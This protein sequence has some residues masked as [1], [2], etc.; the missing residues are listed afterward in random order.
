MP[1]LDSAGAAA[2]PERTLGT[3]NPVTSTGG[4]LFH[5]GEI[6]TS[7]ELQAMRLDGLVQLVIG[8]SYLRSDFREDAAARSQAAARSVPSSLRPR[9]ALGRTCAAWVYGCAPRPSLI[10][11]V[12]DH[13]RRTTALPPFTPAVLHQVALGPF[14]VN[15]VGGVSVTTPLRTALDI[16]VHGEDTGAVEILRAIGTARELA[17]PLRLVEAALVNT[18][19]V[20]GKTRALARLRLA[21]NPG[22]ARG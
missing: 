8:D 7:A 1:P 17:C 18:S 15:L 11:L 19:R 6:F 13:R 14:D 12:T 5:A 3:S 4:A 20:P 16:A 9:V 10:S 22:Q 2:P 21:R